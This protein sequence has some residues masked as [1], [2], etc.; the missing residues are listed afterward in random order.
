L[1][2]LTGYT[3][4]D[5]YRFVDTD[6]SAM[7]LLGT[8]TPRKRF[9]QISQDLRVDFDVGDRFGITVG[10]GIVSA[11][12]DVARR[13]DADGDVLALLAAGTPVEPLAPFITSSPVSHF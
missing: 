7:P 10:A 3:A 13:Q 4:F 8:L 1:T 6:F 5:L 11:T 2:A 9:V 12:L